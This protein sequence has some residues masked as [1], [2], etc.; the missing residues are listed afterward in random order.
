MISYVGIWEHAI[1]TVVFGCCSYSFLRYIQMILVCWITLWQNKWIISW[2]II[3]QE[4]AAISIGT[5][6]PILTKLNLIANLERS[7]WPSGY[8]IIFRLTWTDSV[9]GIHCE[10]AWIWSL[11][12]VRRYPSAMLS[13]EKH[14]ARWSTARLSP[15][16]RQRTAW[17]AYTRLYRFTNDAQVI[18]R[19]NVSAFVCMRMCRLG[20]CTQRARCV[21]DYLLVHNDSHAFEQYAH[22]IQRYVRNA[23]FVWCRVWNAHTFTPT[24]VVFPHSAY[25]C[26]W[27]ACYRRRRQADFVNI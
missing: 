15:I 18:C 26:A 2:W 4:T 20:L 6:A 21:I 7:G 13:G 14:W 12:D 17:F 10:T 9:Y 3:S 5:T 1:H 27:P 11:D 24:V 8:C 19:A 22:Q 23:R 16:Q 25:V